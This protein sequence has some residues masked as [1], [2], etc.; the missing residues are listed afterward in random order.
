M[1]AQ[2]RV[3]TFSEENIMK[4]SLTQDYKLNHSRFQP[5]PHYHNNNTFPSD[6]DLL[7]KTTPATR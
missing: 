3:Q 7:F 4:P 2:T 5:C 1:G 6:V